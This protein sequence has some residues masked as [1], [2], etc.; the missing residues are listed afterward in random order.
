[1]VL[2]VIA[3]WACDLHGVASKPFHTSS[4]PAHVKLSRPQNPATILAGSAPGKLPRISH[5]SMSIHFIVIG[6]QFMWQ[7]TR[8]GMLWGDRT[9]VPSLRAVVNLMRL[10]RVIRDVK[11]PEERH[12]WRGLWL[13]LMSWNYSGSNGSATKII[14]TSRVVICNDIWVAISILK[15]NDRIR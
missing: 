13:T 8:E 3:E 9:K 14:E 15:S 10:N 4:P 1:M 6:R 5:F 7:N 11:T 12:Q 2:V